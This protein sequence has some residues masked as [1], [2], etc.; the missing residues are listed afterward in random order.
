MAALA[1][2]DSVTPSKGL[3]EVPWSVLRIGPGRTPAVLEV[4]INRRGQMA[5]HAATVR[6]DI[7]VFTSIG[8]EHHRS[9][10]SL[11]DTL[12]EKALILS[13]LRPGGLLVLNG[14]DAR[15]RTLASRVRGQI[16]TYGMGDHNDVR[17]TDVH[18]DWPNG[19]RFTLHTPSGTHEARVRLLGRMMVYPILAAVA[20]AHA[21]KRPMENVLAALANVDPPPGRLQLVSLPNGAYVLRDD[22][23][24]SLETIDTAL[25]VLAEIPTRRIAVIGDVSEPPGPQGPIYRRLGE[26][27]ANV[28]DRVIVV[29]EHYHQYATGATRG[30]LA[31]SEVVNAGKSFR[32]AVEEVRSHLRPGDVVLVKGRNTQRLERIVFAL[33]DQLVRCE[34]SFC[35]AANVRCDRCPMLERGWPNEIEASIVGG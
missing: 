28:A 8:S 27:L 24:S 10:G 1:I 6:P 16:L 9:L 17:A 32:R 11:D 34:L 22:F 12:E 30:R 33:Q 26:R 35:R 13:G 21:E 4:S 14:D 15:V 29:G 18:L 7:V 5:R 20:V 2:R 25:D 31:R 23:K 19:T 3:S